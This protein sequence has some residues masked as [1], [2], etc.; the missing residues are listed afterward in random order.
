M[1]AIGETLRRERLRRNLGLEQISRELRI[2]TRMLEAIESDE[3]GKLP[4]Y[5]FAKNFVR[6]YAQLL[7]LDGEEAMAELAKVMEPPSDS[8]PLP[9][10]QGPGADEIRV[11]PMRAWEGVHDGAGFAWGALIRRL[12][13]VVLA[14]MIS[15]GVYALWQR[16]KRPTPVTET[17][18][19]ASQPVPAQ[20]APAQVPAGTADTGSEPQTGAPAEAQPDS[21]AAAQTAAPEAP[22]PAQAAA[23][24]AQAQPGP[25]HVQVTAREEVWVRAVSDGKYLF[26]VTLAANE[27]RSVDGNQFVELRLGNAGGAEISLNGKPVG[28]VGPRGQVRTVQFTPGGF[29]MVSPAAPAAAEDAAAPR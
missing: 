14:V 29:K 13:L 7:G 19:A 5:V 18:R 10:R 27:T 21:S 17:P 11:P 9:L 25:V 23:L 12:G 2:S 24:A 16:S 3:F 28:P 8:V 15:S 1:T 22:V 20:P 6:Q 4:G 26:S